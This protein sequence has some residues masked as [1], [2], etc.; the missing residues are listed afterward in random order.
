MTF[1]EKV[2]RARE[3]AGM[4]QYELAKKMGVSQRTISGYETEGVRARKS[5][6]QKLA[7]ALG[8]SVKY[9]A[10]DECV[11]PLEDIEKDEYVEYARQLYGAKAARDMD[12]LLTES[13]ALF[14]GGELS[15]DQ[16]DA[17]FEAIAIAY[18]SCKQKAKEK[19]GHKD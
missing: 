2:K 19:F 1:S 7:P 16:K 6:L 4:T 14:A 11:N 12:E 15:Q 8:V 5:N 17:Y 10:D 13:A 3:F 18:Y 9:L